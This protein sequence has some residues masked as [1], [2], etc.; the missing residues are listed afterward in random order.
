MTDVGVLLTSFNH[1][2]SCGALSPVEGLE[3]ASPSRRGK[4]RTYRH[5]SFQWRLNSYLLIKEVSLSVEDSFVSD[6]LVEAVGS[7]LFSLFDIGLC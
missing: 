6:V 4:E 7:G 3:Y 5:Q 2:P 1:T